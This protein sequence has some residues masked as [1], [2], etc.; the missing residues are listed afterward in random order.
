MTRRLNLLRLLALAI[1]FGAPGCNKFFAKDAPDDK[2]ADEAGDAPAAGDRPATAEGKCG[3]PGF[4]CTWGE[5]SDEVLARTETIAD[6]GLAAAIE[7]RTVQAVAGAIASEA[8]A[9]VMGKGKDAVRFRVAG[10]RPAWVFVRTADQIATLGLGSLTP[11]AWA[12]PAASEHVGPPIGKSSKGEKPTKKALILSPFQWQW[13]LGGDTDYSDEIERVIGSVEDYE[14]GVTRLENAVAPGGGG[15]HNEVGWVQF[16]QFGQYDAIHVTT[17]GG[18]ICRDDDS[19]DCITALASGEM[20]DHTGVEPEDRPGRDA[21]LTRHGIELGF[22]P[23]TASSVIAAAE[24]GLRPQPIESRAHGG[25]NLPGNQPWKVGPL[26]LLNTDFFKA[27]YPAGLDDKIIFLSACESGV[28]SDLSDALIGNHTAVIGWSQVMQLDVA[29][30]AASCFWKLLAGVRQGAPRTDEDYCQ[31]AASERIDGGRTVENAFDELLAVTALARR[32]G[33]GPV[34]S[35]VIEDAGIQDAVTGAR[36]EPT[37]DRQ[38]RAAEI[39]R[40]YEPD[41]K[42]R[43]QDGDA[44][45]LVG[46][47]GD[48]QPDKL[49]V[50]AELIGISDDENPGDFTIHLTIDDHDAPTTW[51]ATERQRKGVYHG[52]TTVDLGFD[53]E[54]G[55]PFALEPWVEFPGDGLSRWRYEDIRIEYFV[56]TVSGPAFGTPQTFSIRPDRTGFSLF[57]DSFVMMF[58]DRFE[59]TAVSED[60]S[61]LEFCTGGVKAGGLGSYPLGSVDGGI[62]GWKMRLWLQAAGCPRTYAG[63]KNLTLATRGGSLK[64]TERALGRGISRPH[65]KGRSVMTGTFELSAEVTGMHREGETYT[66]EGRFS[67]VE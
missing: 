5:V 33:T 7:K 29:S 53:L 24:L 10:G 67:L 64:V 39:I 36:L 30:L 40:L 54:P 9:I 1:A 25:R 4:P 60:G 18:L 57:E 66:I 58:M 48:G 14:G 34:M 15:I 55:K 46:V 47:P 26:V 20:W 6:V 21:L 17:H 27:A 41:E 22:I 19:A 12:G 59:R 49:E 38:T 31:T 32:R 63:C 16:Q 13:Q 37:G 62:E 52:K 3:A 8:D 65:E 50:V 44:A 42:R 35:I 11:T 23:M 2:K 56:F 28:S 45:K 51:K 43:F 61:S